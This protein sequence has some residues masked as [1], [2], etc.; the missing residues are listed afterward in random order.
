M[1]SVIVNGYRSFANTEKP[2]PEAGGKWVTI[3][4]KNC[5]ICGFDNSFWT[6]LAGGDDFTNRYKRKLHSVAMWDEFCGI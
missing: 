1:K 3:K 4:V 2:M 6:G 5:A